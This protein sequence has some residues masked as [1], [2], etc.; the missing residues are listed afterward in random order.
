[1]KGKNLLIILVINF[2]LIALFS[3]EEP[4]DYKIQENSDYKYVIE[5]S[6]TTIYKK[7]KI[8]ISLSDNFLNK[9]PKK[10]VTNANVYIVSDSEIVHLIEEEPGIYYTPT[11]KAKVGKSYE[12]NVII[13]GI[14]IKGRD[15]IRELIQADSITIVKGREFSY[16][17]NKAIDGYFIFYNGWEKPGK[18][19]CYLF[20]LLI[21][22]EVY[23]DTLNELVYFNDE[24]VDGN[25]IRDL[26]LF[27]VKNEEL[28]DTALIK[29]RVSL[30]SK[31]YYT[32]LNE[33]LMETYWRGAPWDGPSANAKNNLNNGA[34]GYF[35]TADVKEYTFKLIK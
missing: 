17:E 19:D 7:H 27:F 15:T 21:N 4:L 29:V 24:F 33:L 13:N 23:N 22:N 5:G 25:Y 10:M 16:R 11:M 3:C 6:L 31:N 2:G 35:Y 32:Y 9:G 20:E 12:L 8:E 18:G 26:K 30:I 14:H 28:P 34:L 1:M